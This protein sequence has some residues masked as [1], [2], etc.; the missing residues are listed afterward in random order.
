MS[1]SDAEESRHEVH[2]DFIGSNSKLYAVD[3]KGYR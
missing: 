2:L 3:F 1:L